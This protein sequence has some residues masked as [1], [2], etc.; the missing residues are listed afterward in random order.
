MDEW[1]TLRRA[2]KLL[3]CEIAEVMNETT[4]AAEARLDHVANPNKKALKNLGNA[5]RFNQGRKSH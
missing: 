2:R 5:I 4:S 3:V 1:E